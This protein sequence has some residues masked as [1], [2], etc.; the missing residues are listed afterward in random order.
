MS[1]TARQR[2]ARCIRS[3]T[4]CHHKAARHRQPL[5]GT[6]RRATGGCRSSLCAMESRAECHRVPPIATKCTHCAPP[7]ATERCHCVPLRANAF[8]APPAT[9]WHRVAPRPSSDMKLSTFALSGA[10]FSR[11]TV[12]HQAPLCAALRAMPTNADLTLICAGALQEPSQPIFEMRRNGHA[13]QRRPPSATGCYT[14]CT[15]L[16]ATEHH[17]AVSPRDAACRMPPLP[18]SAAECHRA[19][20]SAAERRRAVSLRDAACRM[21]PRSTAAAELH[22]VLQS[23]AE[24]HDSCHRAPSRATECRRVPDATD[25]HEHH[26]A[27]TSVTMHAAARARAHPRATPRTA[28]YRRVPT[29]RRAPSVAGAY[30][31]VHCEPP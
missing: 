16:R 23:V 29:R 12:H 22:R 28:E 17:Q 19:L 5:R 27:P 8:R 20:Q 26:C 18:P 13:S 9:E 30:R 4:A 24:C 25:R 21:P 6:A 2:A 15:H 14:R 3:A 31:R 1:T 7:S 11:A 10:Q